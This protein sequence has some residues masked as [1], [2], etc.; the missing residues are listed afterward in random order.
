MNLPGVQGAVS[1]MTVHKAKGLEFPVVFLP[2]MNQ[3]PR[4][5][6][7]GPPVIIEERAGSVRMAARGGGNPVYADLWEREKEELRREH[8]RLLYV[9]MTRARDHLVMIGTI[10]NGNRPYRQNAWLS[11]LHEAVPAAEMN[12]GTGHRL[13]EY[14]LPDGHARV[15]PADRAAVPGMRPAE[16]L[17]ETVIDADEVIAN[18]A[19][20]PPSKSPEWKRA[21]DLLSSEKEWSLEQPALQEGRILSPLIRGTVFH[22]C[23]EEYSRTGAF[24]LDAVLAGFPEVLSLDR[25]MRDRFAAEAGAVLRSIT[26]SNEL[27][28]IFEPRP[29]S[30]SELPFL[31]RSGNDIVSG[32]ID[33]VVVRGHTGYVIDYKA[34]IIR[35]DDDLQSWIDHYRPQVRVY[36]EAVKALFRLGSVEGYLLFLDSGRLAPTVKI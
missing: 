8:Q 35:S 21:T 27:S 2:G 10:E 14:T 33:R 26:E 22:R 16:P 11:S 28:W 30:Y 6:T 7:T 36:C 18:I 31:F 3:Q 19:P 5:V 13:I 25:E 1:I 4:S 20:I 29:A 15:V 23:L 9:A 17:R 24:D 12:D 32:A 34:T